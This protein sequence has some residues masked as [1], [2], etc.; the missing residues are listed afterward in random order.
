M[1]YERLQEI[2]SLIFVFGI[3]IGLT[4]LRSILRQRER[5]RAEKEKELQ[6]IKDKW[7]Q[8]LPKS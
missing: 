5:E 4:L 1:E 7:K 2:A 3:M 6:S 8:S